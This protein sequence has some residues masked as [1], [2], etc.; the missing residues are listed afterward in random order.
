ML[1][2][3]DATVRFG[4]RIVLDR[5]QLAVAGGQVLCLTGPSGSGKT[6]LLRAIAGLQPVEV[7]T[8]TWDGADVTKVAPH[9][10][11]FGFVFQ[12]GGLFPHLDVAAN[13][14]FGLRLQHRPKQETTE[15]VAELLDLVG[16]GGFDRASV[17]TLSGGERQRVALARA[18]APR[19]R[20]LLLDEPLAALDPELKT[21]LADDLRTVLTTL[22]TTAVYV[23][24][25]GAEAARVGDRTVAL[26]ELSGG[27]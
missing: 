22:R 12:D 5:V 23:T 14:G 19:P 17:A 27:G 2:V 24:H 8:I 6:T 7:G 11:H 20:L 15:R 1:Q 26:G 25:D 3:R 9:R 16:L 18:L 13:V 21:R 10:R 4:N